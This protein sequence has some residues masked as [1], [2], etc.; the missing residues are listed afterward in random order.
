[1]LNDIYN[2]KTFAKTENIG[3]LN[4]LERILLIISLQEED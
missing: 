3:E 1:M 4:N 2:L